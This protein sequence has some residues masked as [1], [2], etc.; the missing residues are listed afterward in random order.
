M[1]LKPM[2]NLSSGWN[3]E[4]NQK[5][6]VPSAESIVD[7]AEVPVIDAAEVPVIDAAEVPVIDAAEVPVIDAVC[8]NC[9]KRFKSMRAVS[10]HLRMTAARHAVN[11]ISHGKYDRKTGLK[12]PELNFI[13]FRNADS[14]LHTKTLGP[15]LLHTKPEDQVTKV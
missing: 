14:G 12:G 9:N 2:N 3:K 15:G 13:H 11:F 1:Y 8:I 5:L 6:E 4:T 7:A 10:M